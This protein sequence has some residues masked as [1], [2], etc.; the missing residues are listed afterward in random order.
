MA[1]PVCR[2]KR[3]APRRSGR[4]L[5]RA[6][7]MKICDWCGRENAD[8]AM[9]CRECGTEKFRELAPPA[10]IAAPSGGLVGPPPLP[11]RPPAVPSQTTAK[12]FRRV[13]IVSWLFPIAGIIA[14]VIGEIIR[15][16]TGRASG[17]CALIAILFFV[18]GVIAGIVA[19]CGMGR[20]SKRGIIGHAL[21][22]I[23]VSIPL[24]FIG[25]VHGFLAFVHNAALL[26]TAHLSPAIHSPSAARR[27]KDEQLQFSIDIPQGFQDFPELKQTPEVAYSLIRRSPDGKT[28]AVITIERM[29]RP[30]LRTQRLTPAQL[31]PGVGGQIA[32]RKWRG[33]DIDVVLSSLKDG[34][35]IVHTYQF[36]VPLRP[37]AIRLTVAETGPESDLQALSRLADTLLASLDG[38]TNW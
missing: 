29:N 3:S 5:D 8:D 30:L 26:P 11:A 1:A 35:A 18:A 4:A 7:T 25:L 19:L 21:A 9:Y 38:E 23:M 15:G 24:V 28:V 34:D 22:G 13:A 10:K 20:Y 32:R 12:P 37:K 36:F 6:C 14:I 17:M 31:V 16:T 33:L 2:C 27:L